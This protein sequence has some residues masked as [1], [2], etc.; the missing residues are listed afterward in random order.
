M[1]RPFASNKQYK[2][3]YYKNNDLQYDSLPILAHRVPSLL[4]LF[5]GVLSCER[6]IFHE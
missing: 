6:F 4:E 1:I 2:A 3:P 5:A